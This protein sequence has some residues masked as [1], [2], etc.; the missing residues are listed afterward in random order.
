MTRSNNA[1]LVPEEHG[2]HFPALSSAEAYRAG[3]LD[4]P[5]RLKRLPWNRDMEA[6]QSMTPAEGL[7]FV[8]R[9][10]EKDAGRYIC[11]I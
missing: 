4:K 5:D 8:A 11:R 3:Y 10:F 9:Y 6:L 2:A 7:K 1:F